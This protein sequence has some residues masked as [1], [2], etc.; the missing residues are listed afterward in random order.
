MSIDR[1]SHFS[2]TALSA[3]VAIVIAAPVLAQNTTSGI[4]G[5]VTDASGKPV[6]GAS[7][8][9]THIESGS[10][11]NATTDAEGRYSARGLRVG[12]PYTI[13]VSQGGR[14][15]RRE[16]VFLVLAE[17]LN[18]DAQLGVSTAT[19]VVTGRAA[20]DKFNRSSM[21]A[22]TNINSAQLNA[23]ASI[24][25]NLQD[26]ARTDPRISQ[27]DKERGEIS[28]G[29]QNSRYNSITIDG[30]NISDTFGLESNNLP[31]AKQ[32]ISID[33]IQSVQVNISNYDVTQKGYTGANINAV[34][35]SGTNEFKGSVYYVWRDEFLT[36]R[37]YNRT[38]DTYSATPAF[39]EDTKGFT[40]GGPII[41]D[42]LFFFASYE[43]QKSSRTSPDF[44]P[45]GSVLT[46]T[47]ISQTSI[48]GLQSIAKNTWGIDLGSQEVPAGTF[49]SVKDA[50]LKLDWTISDNHRA[51]LRY[52]KTDQS[53]PIF[54]N[55]GARALSLSSH[56][57]SQAKTVES[58]VGQWFA[59]WTP[60]F[61]T[62]LKLSKRDYASVPNNNATLPAMLF[63]FNGAVPAGVATGERTLF[64]G[65]ERSRHFNQL[66]TK[67]TDAYLGA[68]WV[69]GKHELKFGADISRNDVFNAFLQDA[70][71]QYKFQCESAY[72]YSFGA[73][74][75]NTA[76]AAQIEAAVLEN[77]RLGRATAYQA[78]LPLVGKSL[79]DGVARWNLN[80]L[81][82]F[83][84]DTWAVS[85]KLN[86][87]LGA[88]LDN[89]A[90]PTSPLRN[91]AAS[92]PMVAGNPATNTRQSGGFGY[93]N[94][95]TIDGAS[96]FQPR[97]GFNL[98]LGSKEQ[99]RQ[100][101]GG[102]GL[103]EGAAA[104]VWLS[105]PYS[106]T[107][108]AMAFFGCGLSAEL[109]GGTAN[110]TACSTAGV[111]NPNS[112]AQAALGAN[113]APA[114][115]MLDPGLSQPSVW[116]GN[117]A[118]ETELPW[119]GLV[120]SAEWLHTKSR[121]GIYYKHLNLGPVTRT[122]PDGRELYYNANGFDPDCWTT[123]GAIAA[124][125]PGC[126]GA[127]L[128]KS[129]NNSAFG[130]VLLASGSAK[131]GGNVI[132]LGLSQQASRQFGW[133][134]AYT[135]SAAKEVS[136]LTSSV[137]NSNFNARSIFNPNEE[138]AANSAYVIRD[139]V[140]AAVT[141]SKAFIGS[142]RTTF[143]M[144]YE[145]RAGKP[146]SWTFNNDM[147][148]DGLA[149]N[150]LMYIPKA[151]GS[152]EVVFAGGAADE[153]RFWD[154]VYRDPALTNARG[155]VVARN[156]S[157]APFVNNFDL[158]VSQELPGFSAKHK[159]VITFDILNFGNLL[160]KRWGRI[161]EVA[162]QGSGAAARSFV[163]YKGLDANGKY[164]YSTFTTPESLVTRQVKGESQWA[165]QVTLRYEF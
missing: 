34:T 55:F 74:N 31:T 47:G 165:V 13:T 148:G 106:N 80:N 10:T 25:R 42:K 109:T 6:A 82:L 136:P 37:R 68:T 160:D 62:E 57:Y 123:G 129:L 115:D 89:T 96:L 44:G 119:H 147:N 90:I 18:L 11:S 121:Q 108:I 157:F 127:P 69:L 143:G 102:I 78:Q 43:E 163:N 100:L 58:L 97:I 79:S 149:G 21:G 1:F 118:F 153:A 46:N 15:D 122:G 28:A 19:V 4:A 162:F 32:P 128:S 150:D 104:N 35:K 107:G 64:T 159:G 152:G 20:N 142:Y 2:R 117:L 81:G 134:M 94:S 103:F 76:T 116:K 38:N 49:L 131:G 40:L 154:V 85:N 24:Q 56:W 29:G 98:D 95:V 53:E 135:R 66:I 113:P 67:T 72:T 77:F 111:F 120:A 125:A 133:S 16:G 45:I 33:A 110:R 126:A 3:A 114:V 17:T 92:A 59:D 7:V 60:T 101:R 48:T 112:A 26:Y 161:D 87:T 70:N 88:R 151:P 105:N 8:S 164:V 158:R 30:V 50:L 61:S 65:T 9:I 139:R 91:A 137:A 5:Q 145:G 71:G 138:V 141:W 86:V 93:D 63:D 99:R 144:F 146:Y 12:G 124:T 41:K 132:T 155:G 140:S 75:C 73:I 54:S 156:S 39:D 22:G 51:N 27:T 36:G 130:N 14:S 23:L 84:Q 52:T 83:V